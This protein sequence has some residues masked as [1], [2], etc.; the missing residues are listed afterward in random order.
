[1]EAVN[2]RRLGVVALTAA[3]YVTLTMLFHPISYGPVQVRVAEA[4]TVL[5]YVGQL[6]IPGL[7]LGCLLANL[8]GG[9][10]VYDVVL[11][12]AATLVAALL[13]RKMPRPWLAPLPPVVV[14]A[15]VVGAYLSYLAGLP[16]FWTALY[17]GLGQLVAC[18]GLG[19]PLLLAVLRRPRWRAYLDR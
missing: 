10:G 2:P 11:G 14:N 6:A 1:V 5:P 9:W 8:L 15:V 4:L 18:Y 3:A 19:Y 13:T 12:S 7:F 17:V 16:Y